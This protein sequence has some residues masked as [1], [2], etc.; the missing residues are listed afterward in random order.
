[1]PDGNETLANFERSV[2]ANSEA[3][4]TPRSAPSTDYH[5]PMNPLAAC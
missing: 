4:L 2:F 3:A 5:A 1:M